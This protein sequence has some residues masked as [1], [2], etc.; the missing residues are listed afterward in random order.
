M[1]AAG[2]QRHIRRRHGLAG[3]GGIPAVQHQHAAAD[4]FH[5]TEIHAIERRRGDERHHAHRVETLSGLA[6]GLVIMCGGEFDT[7]HAHPGSAGMAQHSGDFTG[8]SQRA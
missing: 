7:K 6:D 3:E 2:G 8:G 5:G 1:E 4:F